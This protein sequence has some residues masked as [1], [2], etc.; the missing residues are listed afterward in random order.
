MLDSRRPE[1][2]AAIG[3]V[4]LLLLLWLMLMKPF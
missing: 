1:I 4:A 2:I 3:S